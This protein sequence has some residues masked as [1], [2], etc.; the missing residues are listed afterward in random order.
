[1]GQPLVYTS[2]TV[3]ASWQNV[4]TYPRDRGMRIPTSIKRL[5]LGVA[6]TLETG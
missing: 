1:M 2:A 5:C 3:D 4:L 6:A